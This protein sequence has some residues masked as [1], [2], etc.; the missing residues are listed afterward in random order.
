MM[1]NKNVEDTQRIEKAEE[2]IKDLKQSLE[3]LTDSTLYL[4]LEVNRLVEILI[5]QKK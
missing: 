2:D 1:W 3:K 4:S 5:E